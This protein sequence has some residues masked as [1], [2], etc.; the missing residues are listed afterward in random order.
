MI[1]EMTEG[2]TTLAVYMGTLVLCI[3]LVSRSGR[4]P[5][6]MVSTVL[7]P[8]L[9]ATVLI[10]KPMNPYQN[11]FAKKQG[12][13]SRNIKDNK[14]ALLLLEI[15]KSTVAKQYVMIV[16]AGLSVLST[17]LGCCFWVLQSKKFLTF[18]HSRDPVGL[19][20][21][22]PLSFGIE[23]IFLLRWAMREMST[24]QGY[25]SP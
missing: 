9:A 11:L 1:R 10:A 25:Q 12:I 24:R 21:T 5:A 7:G 15:L 18:D 22:G 13:S 4:L 8:I 6:I 3:F 16:A 20:L 23:S 19:I 2:N 17:I 14:L